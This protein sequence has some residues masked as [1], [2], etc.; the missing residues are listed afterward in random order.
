VG[1]VTYENVLNEGSSVELSLTY[2]SLDVGI[3]G[4]S[5]G[6]GGQGK[7][8]IYFADE[9]FL[10]GTGQEIIPI[11]SIDHFSLGDGKIGPI[12]D[13]IRQDYFTIVRDPNADHKEWRTLI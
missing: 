9:A 8:K 10:C 3:F 11:T 12:T 7:Y 1:K 5:T 6:L 13:N 2:S 4:K